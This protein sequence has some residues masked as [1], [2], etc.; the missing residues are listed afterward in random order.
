MATEVRGL[1]GRDEYEEML[2]VVAAG[3]GHELERVR[4]RFERHPPYKLENTRVTIVDGKIV[5]VVHV[6]EL[7]VRGRSGETWLMGGIGE[8]ATPPE[9]R[10]QGYSTLALKDSIAFME[11]IGCHFSMLGTGIPAFYER[12][13]WQSYPRSILT[14]DPVRVELPEKPGADFAIREVDWQADLPDLK[15]IHQAFN[16]DT[17]G[18]LVRS[19][20]YWQEA[21]SARRI[22]GTSWVALD[23]GH[24]VA[25]LWG[26]SELHIMELAHHEGE[27]QAARALLVHALQ[28]ARN[29]GFRQVVVEEAVSTLAAELARTQPEGA[30]S[31]SETTGTMFRPVAPGFSID[32]AP[33]EFVYY[34]TDGF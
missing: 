10:R 3:F 34:R 26:A 12:L 7:Q 6:H 2:A 4:V 21:T 25:Y 9:H 29:E 23:D 27:E 5:S 14:F 31:R 20:E 11:Q 24:A 22:S 30:V 19:D 1:K 33:G 18:P 15:R 16:R 8:V 13:G 17:M 32:F 28:T